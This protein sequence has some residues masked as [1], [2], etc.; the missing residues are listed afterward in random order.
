MKQISVLILILLITILPIFAGNEISFTEEMLN[1]SVRQFTEKEFTEIDQETVLLLKLL[2]SVENNLSIGEDI[3]KERNELIEKNPLSLYDKTNFFNDYD[4]YNDILWAVK[5]TCNTVLNY[6]FQNE[7]LDIMARTLYFEAGSNF[8]SDHC[9]EMV[10]AVM[11]NRVQSTLFN[12]NTIKEVVYAK[13]QYQCAK[14]LYTIDITERP[15]LIE[16]AKRVLQGEEVCPDNVVFQAN[17][18]Q[19]EGIY[20]AISESSRWYSFTLYFCY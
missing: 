9:K 2:Y 18:P 3:E 7:D 19:G 11:R 15:D 8:I 1:Q 20:E 5:D 13:G 4:N 16:I 14:L 6:G 12:G 10:C 17:F